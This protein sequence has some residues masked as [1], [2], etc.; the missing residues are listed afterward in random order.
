MPPS[1]RSAVY[2]GSVWHS[3]DLPKPHQFRYQLAY[4]VID[5]DELEQLDR[6]SRWF[7]VNRRAWFS[8]HDEDFG[9][10]S[11][12]PYRE[13]LDQTLRNRGWRTL[14]SRYLVM[15]LP[16][17]LGYCFNPLT[18][19]HGLDTAGDCMVAVYEVN[20]TNR[21]RTHYIVTPEDSRCEKALPVSPFFNARGAYKFSGNIPDETLHLSIVYQDSGGATLKTGFTAR[22]RPFVAKELRWC[23]VRYPLLALSVVFSIH[24]QALKIWRKGVR[25]IG[26]NRGH[27]DDQVSQSI[28]ETV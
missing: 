21:E 24:F 11:G 28:K 6:V 4:F 23:A 2:H 19:V 27:R 3:R 7:G 5:L 22:R 16:R 8:W 10:G 12:Q 25:F 17:T 1:F 13:F 14:P 26:L 18:V 15:T 20:N 9:D